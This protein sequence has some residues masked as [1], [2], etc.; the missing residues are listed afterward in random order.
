[1]RFLAAF[2]FCA[3][4]PIGVALGQQPAANDLSGNWMITTD[5]FGTTVYE[6]MELAKSGNNVTGKYAGDK[7]TSAKITGGAI[8]LMAASD[9]NAS[10]GDRMA[11]S[12]PRVLKSLSSFGYELP[13]I[14]GGV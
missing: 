4:T 1:M 13:I 7:I 9:V 14:A 12:A 3:S 5:L 6:R 2:L 10:S 8:H 11:Y